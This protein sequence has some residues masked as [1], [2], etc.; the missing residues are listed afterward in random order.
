MNVIKY[1]AKADDFGQEV[2]MGVMR[3]I[4]MFEPSFTQKDIEKWKKEGKRADAKV[5][6][7]MKFI[8][9]EKRRT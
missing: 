9:V 5:E 6:L 1:L 4:H 8:I 2:Y 3:Q 7:F